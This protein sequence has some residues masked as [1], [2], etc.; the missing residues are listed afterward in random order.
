MHKAIGYVEQIHPSPTR[1]S[2]LNLSGTDRT[3][4]FDGSFAISDGYIPFV[5]FCYPF[6]DAKF[7]LWRIY[8][9]NCSVSCLHGKLRDDRLGAHGCALLTSVQLP[10]RAN[11]ERR[12]K[13]AKTTSQLLN[14]IPQRRCSPWKPCRKPISCTH[15]FDLMEKRKVP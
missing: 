15:R 7:S 4:H 6:I 13:K 1:T 8:H 5:L 10:W 14:Y 11:N 3:K 12:R 2:L 9:K